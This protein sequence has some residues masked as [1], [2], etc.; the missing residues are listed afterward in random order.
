MIIISAEISGTLIVSGNVQYP[1]L[2]Q[3]SSAAQ[4]LVLD[5]NTVKWQV[6]GAS[7]TSGTSGITGTSG[8]SGTSGNSG[9][10]G[11]AGTSGTSG[12][13]GITGTS[14]T[15][16]TS[17]NSGTSGAAGTSGTSGTSG[18]TGTSGTSGTSGTTP[19][20]ATFI[21]NSQ[22][23][24]MSV[25]T[26]SYAISSSMWQH[27]GSNIYFPNRV[28]IGTASPLIGGL[29]VSGGVSFTNLPPYGTTAFG[30]ISSTTGWAGSGFLFTN[31]D[32]GTTAFSMVYNG[33][34]AFFGSI[35][36][37]ANSTWAQWNSTGLALGISWPSTPTNKLDISGSV[38]I[39]TY[40]GSNL[41]PSNS[42]IVSDKIGIATI[43][44]A[45]PL[46]VSGSA[47]ITGNL[48]VTGSITGSLFGT[49]SY[50][51]TASYYND[52]DGAYLLSSQTGSFLNSVDVNRFGFLNQTETTMSFNGTSSFAL[53]GS[54]WSY[55]RSGLKYT[56]TGNKSVTVASPM[57]DNTIYYIYIDSTDGTLSSS[58]T[59]WTL[60]DTKVPVCT[61][62]WN[63]TQTPKFIL[64]E[65][66]HTCLIDRRV[67]YC[68]HFTEGT[69]MQTVGD[70]SGSVINTDTNVS[71]V[72]SIG[73]SILLDEDII[74]NI[75][76]ISQPDG[77][78][79][80]YNIIYRSG[81]SGRNWKTS[82]MPF[83]YNVGNSNNVI[84][85]D[86][87]SVMT[88]AGTG[89]AGNT[90][91]V[92]SYLCFSNISGSFSQFII[93]GRAQ[94]TS[95]VLAQAEDPSTFT[96][97]NF[98]CVEFSIA[99]RL[100]W[101]TVTSTSQGKCRLAADPQKIAIAAINTS[102][103]GGSIQHNTLAGLDGGTT[104]EYYHLTSAQYTTMITSA[105]VSTLT[106]KRIQPR[107]Y[108]TSSIGTLTPE[109][110]NYDIFHITALTGSLTIA[111]HST[112]TPVDG[113]LL[114][115]RLLD[116][117]VAHSISYGT[118]YVAK[119]G[120]ALP[121]TTVA[122]KNTEMLF[123]WNNNLTKFNLMAV[124]QEA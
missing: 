82:N 95:L 53:S 81:S 101:T 29:Q 94:F 123:E 9:T 44:P 54:S 46:D 77:T 78:A 21:Q 62:Y 31:T 109:I 86:S 37:A 117:G 75:T 30:N 114:E 35:T 4:F 87:S 16:G 70:L 63:S 15:S 52:N 47:R 7:G 11:A 23:S 59:S 67:H 104:G 112:S 41:A 38:A 121:T 34:K 17:G 22:T 103:T 56:I 73:S 64:S 40:A 49:A 118:N 12:T 28:A 124:G 48:I 96:F 14:G 33:D 24:S 106:N 113:E 65:E 26:A 105:S 72:F 102:A 51:T 74:Q 120:V 6:G 13:S 88:D 99:Y 110:A 25:S 83:V 3:T 69:R 89:N 5:N 108:T 57:V 43:I 36:A 66:R 20:T 71:K 97:T 79:A 91:W 116:N 107:T 39:G 45:Y 93:P 10:S 32:T 2:T 61:I 100:T 115:I 50:A 27:N 8:T 92:N 60:N 42:L 90:R 119:A 80:V 76:G 84:Q 55:Y 68:E 18:I 122:S 98:P 19:S 1:T 111:N 85:Y 58:A